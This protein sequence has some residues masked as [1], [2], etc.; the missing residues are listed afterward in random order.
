M[1]VKKQSETENQEMLGR[2]IK[3][4]KLQAFRE[5]FRELNSEEQKRVKGGVVISIIGVLVGRGST[6]ADD[7]QP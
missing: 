3:V 1:V 6:P 7:R 4:G 5:R 2:K